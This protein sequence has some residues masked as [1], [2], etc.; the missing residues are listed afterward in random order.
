MRTKLSAL[1]ACLWICGSPFQKL[2]AE[3]IRQPVVSV[4]I[5]GA[6]KYC[7]GQPG[8][9][10]NE[11]W[12][13]EREPTDA[14]T[15]RL[16]GQLSFLNPGLKPLIAPHVYHVSNLIVSRTRDD[17]ARGRHQLVIPFESTKPSQEDLDDALSYPDES[18]ELIQPGRLA[19]SVELRRPS[20]IILRVRDPALPGERQLLGKKVF[21]Q[22]ELA[23]L[24]IPANVA[25]EVKKRWTSGFLWT[26][27]VRTNPF[28]IDIPAT[29]EM[30]DCSNLY[31]ID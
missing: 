20:N 5:V 14:I 4:V 12:A 1:S 25:K 31:K 18:F 11:V 3:D 16:V 27:K 21:L 24:Q 15:I 22:L 28:E 26:A 13:L 29:P 6:Q 7:L 17:A 10:L 8:G 23:P 9:I 2:Q 30:A 19:S